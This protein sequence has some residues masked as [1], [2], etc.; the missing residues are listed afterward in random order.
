MRR[1]YVT[2][3][4]TLGPSQHRKVLLLIMIECFG[5]GAGESDGL[6]EAGAAVEGEA[7]GDGRRAVP[8]N[9]DS[10][11]RGANGNLS[12]AQDWDPLTVGGVIKRAFRNGQARLDAVR[13]PKRR[14]R[15]DSCAKE[16]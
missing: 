6:G 5:H 11:G 10:R 16:T 14:S 13:P 1:P 12:N 4:M 15:C 9:G 2:R 8:P 3:N 7:R